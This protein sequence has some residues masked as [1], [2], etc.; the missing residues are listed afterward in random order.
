MGCGRFGVGLGLGQLESALLHRAWNG[1]VRMA[2]STI[3]Q[4]G[5]TPDSI[6]LCP[7]AVVIL[8]PNA[9]LVWK[10]CNSTFEEVLD[11]P[12]FIEQPGQVRVQVQVSVK[13]RLATLHQEYAYDVHLMFIWCSGGTI[14]HHLTLI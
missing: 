9:Q 2:S 5:T 11:L 7:I 8:S 14:W 6:P 3:R 4:Y 10:V 13:V 12:A 1:M